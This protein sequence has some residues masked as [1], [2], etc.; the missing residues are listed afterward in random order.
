M[1]IAP[2][3]LKFQ[4]KP[5][6]NKM[7]NSIAIMSSH[8]DVI[9]VTGRNI[10][11]SFCLSLYAP[12]TFSSTFGKIARERAAI[13]YVPFLSIQAIYHRKNCNAEKCP[14]R[15]FQRFQSGEP[16]W[17]TTIENDRLFLFSFFCK[18]KE[19]AGFFR[20]QDLNQNCDNNWFNTNIYIVSM[21][22]SRIIKFGNSLIQSTLVKLSLYSMK[23]GETWFANRLLMLNLLRQL[24]KLVI[25]ISARS[26]LFGF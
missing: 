17:N 12:C 1:T 4:Y 14:E 5:W 15:N 10:T 18:I 3:L 16:Y 7:T 19:L 21:I 9:I 22:R 8:I 13:T 6:K 11:I 26:H 23:C 24:C 20:G 25:E 2:R